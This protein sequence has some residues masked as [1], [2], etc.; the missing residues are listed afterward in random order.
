MTRIL[1]AMIVVGGLMIYWGYQEMSLASKTEATAQTITCQD[2]SDSGPGD[3]ANVQMSEF[4]LC[5]MSYVYEG[6]GNSD[7]TYK[8]VWVPAVP[9]NGD[10]HQQ[11][12]TMI[13]GE[14]NLIGD[15]PMPRDLGVLSRLPMR[16]TITPSSIWPTGTRSAGL[17]STRSHRSDRTRRRS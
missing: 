7:T 13:D 2:L 3:N 14:G 11:L 6:V 15:P 10:Y 9:L 17:S 8:T 16:P 1:I 5:T 12:M 4:L